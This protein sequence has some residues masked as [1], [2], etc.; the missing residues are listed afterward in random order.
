MCGLGGYVDFSGRAPRPDVLREMIRRLRHRGPDGE[1]LLVDGP[2]GLAH[3]R[4]GILDLQGGAQPMSLPGSSVSLVYNGE[5]YNY[6]SLRA[7][8]A[9]LGTPCA[10]SGDTEVVLRMLAC[11]W[12]RALPR[13]DG[14][15][16]LAAWDGA[17]RRLLLARGPFGVKPLFYATPRP[18]LIVFGSEIK[19]VLAHDE[20]DGALDTDGLRQTL[21]FRTVH[22]E[23]TLYRG[24][25]QLLPGAFLVIDASGATHGSYFDLDE[26]VRAA[27]ERLRGMDEPQMIELGYELF[28]QS[29]RKRLVA[30]VPVGVFFSGG[31]DSSLVAGAMRQM[32]G[33][34]GELRSFTAAFRDDPSGEGAHA[35]IVARQLGLAHTQVELGEEEYIQNFAAMSHHRDAPVSEPADLAMAYL[36]AAARES[37]KVVLVGEGAD[38]VFCGYP[39][40][41]LARCPAFLRRVAG[42]LSPEGWARA[43]GLVGVDRHRAL[44]VAR[45]LSSAPEHERL[46][47]WFSAVDRPLLASLLPGLEWTDAQW[48]RTHAMHELLGRRSERLGAIGRMQLTDFASWLPDNLMA[49]ADRMTMA[50]GLELREPFLDHA[51][52]VFGLALPDSMKV[53][54]L[55]LKWMLRRWAHHRLPASVL[56]RP[57]WG[58]RV[59]LNRWFRQG[60]RPMLLDSLRSKRGLCGTFG[61]R[62]AIER[63]LSAHD[64]GATDAHMTLWTLLAAEVWYQ[65]VFLPSA[66][67]ASEPGA[68]ALRH[69]A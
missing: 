65:Q 39:K 40:Y 44:V 5:V 59:P 1:G 10:G 11:H 2:C 13:F 24:V 3:T 28:E 35:R 57:K 52:A 48:H 68:T 49:R 21:R 37:V 45:A 30:D 16:G 31:L 56:R 36:S 58:F 34:A 12:T 55:T 14:M 60:L 53:R 41:A 62:T 29:V 7:E 23:G 67:A 54:G 42:V 38:E 8:L 43:G 4:L 22:G 6:Q 63:L 47:Q 50:H 15:F 33:P 26:K 25:R 9:T 46:A 66:R 64:R 17:A 18:D 61:D 69:A 51:L 19:A 20:V 32:R 27:G